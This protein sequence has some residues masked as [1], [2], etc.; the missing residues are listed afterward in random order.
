MEVILAYIN[1][2]GPTLNQHWVSI[3]CIRWVFFISVDGTWTTWTSWSSCT[4]V[5]GG[6]IQERKRSCT[7]PP[8]RAAGGNDCPGNNTETKACLAGNIY[9]LVSVLRWRLWI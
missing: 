4:S 9:I 6:G 7:D 8:P 1:D 5:C 3:F 2:A